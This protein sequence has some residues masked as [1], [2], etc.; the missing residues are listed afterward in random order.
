MMRL[1]IRA[2][3]GSSRAR[4]ADVC[5]LRCLFYDSS[6]DERTKVWCTPFDAGITKQVADQLDCI[7]TSSY[8]N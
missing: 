1:V 2:W 3:P 8:D 4:E 5:T 7:T 6:H